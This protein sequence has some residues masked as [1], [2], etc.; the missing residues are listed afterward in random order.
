[1]E[2]KNNTIRQFSF[3]KKKAKRMI[4]SSKNNMKLHTLIAKKKV[5]EDDEPNQF[6]SQVKR[7]TKNKFNSID[8]IVLRNNIDPNNNIYEKKETTSPRKPRKILKNKNFEEYLEKLYDDEPH[9]KKSIF[10][11]SNNAKNFNRKVSFLKPF[12][13]KR[14][15]NINEKSIIS[16]KNNDFSKSR[17]FNNDDLGDESYGY[18]K[19]YSV[20][21]FTN[22]N[23]NDLRKTCLFNNCDNREL[24]RKQSF[25]TIKTVNFGKMRNSEKKSTNKTSTQLRKEKKKDSSKSNEKKFKKKINKLIKDKE[26]NNNIEKN[27]NNI[28]NSDKIPIDKNKIKKYMTTDKFEIDKKNKDRN[29]INNTDKKNPVLSPKKS[30]ENV[31]T[32]VQVE[33]QNKKKRKK[34]FFCCPFL[35]CLKM[36]NNEENN[37]IIK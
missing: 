1:M 21:I 19:K 9:L 30:I 8:N 16:G 11:K 29:E 28:N 7:P 22:T 36:S 14:K 33:E 13:N 12:N 5:I 34:Q 31:E 24:M 15:T 4:H 37:N 10:K 2:K 35:I 25:K 27:N 17:I 20:N 26:N 3:H 6:S 18:N 23:N 32:L